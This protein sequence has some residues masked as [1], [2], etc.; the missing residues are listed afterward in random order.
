MKVHLFFIALV[1]LFVTVSTLAVAV[2]RN[3]DFTVRDFFPTKDEYA[4]RS[5][6]VVTPHLNC[7]KQSGETHKVLHIFIKVLL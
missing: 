6:K 3:G 1:S 7:R 4:L 5:W 2:N